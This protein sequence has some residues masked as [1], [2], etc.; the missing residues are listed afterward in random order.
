MFTKRMN[1]KFTVEMEDSLKGFAEKYNFD[2][3]AGNISYDNS[4]NIK[5]EV[6]QKSM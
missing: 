1:W 4:F 5:I 2:I 6:R 3:K